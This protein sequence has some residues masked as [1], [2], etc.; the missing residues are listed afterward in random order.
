MYV[1]ITDIMYVCAIRDDTWLCTTV[2]SI[3]VCSHVFAQYNE[4]GR[5]C[6][7]KSG[8]T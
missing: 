4:M 5:N 3:E 2:V 1:H 6:H 8:E 7:T